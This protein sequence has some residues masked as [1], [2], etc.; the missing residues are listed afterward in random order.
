MLNNVDDDD[1]AANAVGRVCVVPGLLASGVRI[2]LWSLLF[3]LFM[4][5]FINMLMWCVHTN[6]AV[7]CF[8]VKQGEIGST[9]LMPRRVALSA[10]FE[11]HQQ[12]RGVFPDLDTILAA[13][14]FSGCVRGKMKEKKVKRFSGLWAH[15]ASRKTVFFLVVVCSP[16]TSHELDVF[17][18]MKLS[19]KLKTIFLDEQKT[20]W[21]LPEKG[22]KLKR[23]V[24][25]SWSIRASKNISIDRY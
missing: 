22:T 20:K 19:V 21:I 1:A 9:L 5:K 15:L 3:T 14:W 4:R 13:A 10:L 11:H 24:L 2:R 23:D 25:E 6:A 7:K 17:G 8:T 16:Y 18:W 12:D